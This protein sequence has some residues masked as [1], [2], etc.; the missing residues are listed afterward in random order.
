MDI[1]RY[2]DCSL[3]KQHRYNYK[4]NGEIQVFHSAENFENICVM[5]EE[6]MG[7]LNRIEIYHG[8]I[9]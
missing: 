4:N 3:F 5:L 8:R 2:N 1:S 9:L 7:Y 6:I